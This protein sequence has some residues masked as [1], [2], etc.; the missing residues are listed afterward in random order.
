MKNKICLITGATSGIGKATA[1][2]LAKKGAATIII[3]R[4]KKRCEK[5]IKEIIKSTGNSSIDYIV[6]DLSSMNDVRKLY[7]EFKSRYNRLDVLINNVGA[8]FVKR[9][10]SVDGYEMTL[11]LNH[12]S[13][14]LLTN[15]L[16]DMLKNSG[17]ARIIN[18]SSGSHG[19]CPG[20]NFDDLQSERQYIGKK[21][22]AQSKL[23]NILFTYE[24]SRRLES[25]GV[26]ANA[27]NPGGVISNFCLNNGLI[28]WSKHVIAHILYRNL[29]GPVEGARTSVYLA[30]SPEVEGVTGK[31]FYNI[32]PVRSSD[33]SYDVE[34][35][36]NLWNVS[37]KL[38]GNKM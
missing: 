35:A 14:F 34:M 26:T 15:L 28:S 6:A 2:A 20:I 25:T 32:K 8:K 4:N 36:K 38:T 3:G 31:Y 18:V 27:V 24:L 16:M 13:H 17:R 1:F 23:A 22:Y 11:S 5:T 29:I 33:T 21:A 9:L 7:I 30:S 37:K 12:L 10:V 19:G